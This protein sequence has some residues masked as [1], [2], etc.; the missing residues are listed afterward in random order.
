MQT[1]YLAWLCLVIGAVT[2]VA[3]TPL[4]SLV[5]ARLG[6]LEADR[7]KAHQPRLPSAGGVVVLVG[8]LVVGMVLLPIG[9]L[10]DTSGA[11][12][13]TVLL[14]GLFGLFDDWGRKGLPQGA[15]VVVPLLLALP[16][17]LT[18]R[19][20]TP[21]GWLDW[22]P[23]AL[24][25]VLVCLYLT[26]TANLHNMH[27][28]YN[29]LSCGLA[30]LLLGGLCLKMLRE[31]ETESLPLAAGLLGTTLAFLMFNRYPARVL[32]G[33]TGT[34]LWGAAV[35]G[36]LVVQGWPLM[37]L[38][39]LAPHIVDL[40]L[41]SYARS[42]GHKFVKF[43]VVDQG[44]QLR[45]EDPFKLKFIILRRWKLTELHATVLLWGLTAL[46]VLMALFLPEG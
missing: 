5:A 43:G 35:G 11:L 12:L 29:G 30:V 24:I 22:A 34:Y 42:K 25:V 9:E 18:L 14:F 4:W 17:A 32:E 26:A 28:G 6:L 27:A 23:S 33:D 19:D 13:V 40:L 45:S 39:M 7:Y 16:L 44:G 37:G 20:D 31:G 3:I 2:A 36:V 8:A 1:G 38:V 46:F 41:W 10:S 21:P 15:K